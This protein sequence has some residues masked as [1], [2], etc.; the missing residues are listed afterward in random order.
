MM[1]S[2]EKFWLCVW[3]MVLAFLIALIV[4]VTVIGFDKRDKWDKAV[5]NGAD[6]MVASCALYSAETSGEIG[7]CTILAQNRK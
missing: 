5:S 1:D 6:P 7:I 2:N 4:C 3:G